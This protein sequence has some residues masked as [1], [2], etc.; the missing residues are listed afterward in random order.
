MLPSPVATPTDAGQE[1]AAHPLTFAIH[2]SGFV[3]DFFLVLVPN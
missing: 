1:V 3:F 2:T